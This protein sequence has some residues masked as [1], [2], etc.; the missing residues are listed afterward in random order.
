MI[1]KQDATNPLLLLDLLITS[2][3]WYSKYEIYSIKRMI[4]EMDN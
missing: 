1:D 4:E 3:I 2:I